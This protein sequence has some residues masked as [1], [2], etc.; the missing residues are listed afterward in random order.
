MYLKKPSD[1]LDQLAKPTFRSRYAYTP[2]DW[3]RKEWRTDGH[4]RIYRQTAEDLA[5]LRGCA[6]LFEWSKDLKL[7]NSKAFFTWDVSFIFQEVTDVDLQRAK[8]GEVTRTAKY[9]GMTLLSVTCFV[10]I[11]YYF[12]RDPVAFVFAFGTGCPCCIICC[13]CIRKFTD[14]YLNV[15]KI[16]RDS[17]NRYMPGM[18]INDDGSFETY[19]PTGEELAI[20]EEI[21]DEIMDWIQCSGRLVSGAELCQIVND[22]M[23][24]CCVKITISLFWRCLHSN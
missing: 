1:K 18:I 24:T 15:K 22:V 10:F 6:C 14:K 19:E 4:S 23:S 12:I 17:M 8:Y 3:S 2:F 11:G 20:M 21:L 5:P 13:P 9:V 16:I 7:H